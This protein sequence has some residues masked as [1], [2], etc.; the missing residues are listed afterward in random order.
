MLQ[1]HLFRMADN[2]IENGLIQQNQRN[3]AIDALREEWQDKMAISFSVGNIQAVAR[4]NGIELEEFEG[5]HILNYFRNIALNSCGMG[6]SM[7]AI[8]IAL[9]NCAW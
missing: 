6:L 2:L 1:G 7:D 4:E 9:A 3:D 8:D 5:Y